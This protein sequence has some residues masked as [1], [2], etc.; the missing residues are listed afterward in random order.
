M[1]VILTHMPAESFTFSLLQCFYQS[2]LYF[3]Q[4]S[5]ST[6]K[7]VAFWSWLAKTHKSY[8]L[9]RLPSRHSPK[10]HSVL[11]GEVI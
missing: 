9:L 6:I 10:E 8:M 1:T 7:R 11:P 4:A 2:Q 5:L 3:V